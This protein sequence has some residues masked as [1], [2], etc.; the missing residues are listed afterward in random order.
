[1]E[2]YVSTIEFRLLGPVEMSRDTGPVPLGG[3][4][5]QAIVAALVLEPNR[6]V[7]LDQL[8]AS[9]WGELDRRQDSAEDHGSRT[10]AGVAQF[11][12]EAD[13]NDSRQDQRLPKVSHDSGV[14]VVAA[15]SVVDGCSQSDLQPQVGHVLQNVLVRRS[16]LRLQERQ[17]RGLCVVGRSRQVCR[18]DFPVSAEKP[19]VLIDGTVDVDRGQTCLLGVGAAPPPRGVAG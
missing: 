13:A 17:S 14:G 2:V 16:G 11:A 5:G 7:S 4:R 18:S 19:Q 3:P 1:L 9:A 10:H 6:F 15:D 12:A 8:V